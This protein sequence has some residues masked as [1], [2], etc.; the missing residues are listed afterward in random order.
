M[1]ELTALQIKELL[2]KSK[3]YTSEAKMEFTFLRVKS[4]TDTDAV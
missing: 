3:I 4:L 1:K 2:I